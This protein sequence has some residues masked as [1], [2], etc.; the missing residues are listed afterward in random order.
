M[1]VLDKLCVP[2]AVNC[3]LDL[4]WNPVVG[5]RIELEPF[6]EHL[7]IIDQ[8]V[9]THDKCKFIMPK[10]ERVY[11]VMY[12]RQGPSTVPSTSVILEFSAIR[13]RAP[14]NYNLWTSIS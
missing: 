4:G 6:A 2:Y 9:E 3:F 7:K 8:H 12:P 14:V 10:Y 13:F 1:P 5:E 11:F